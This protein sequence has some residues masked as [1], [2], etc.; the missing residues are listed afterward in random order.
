V[1]GIAAAIDNDFGVVGVAPGARLWAVKVLNKWG[2][3]S[4]SGVIAGIDWVTE[5][6]SEIE[7]ANLSLGTV[8]KS[9]AFRLA[10][11]NSTAAGI[12]Y[13]VAAGNS[14]KDVY[15]DDGTFDTGDDFIPA[16]YPEV[17]AVSAIADS[18]GE[19]GGLGPSTSWGDDDTLALFSN[20]SRDVVVDNPVIA[21]GAAI[22]V[23]APGVDILSTW[24]GNEYNTLSGTSMASPHVAGRAASYI[25]LHGKPLDAEGVATVRQALISGGA[26][27]DGP[28]GFTL[29]FDENPEPLVDAETL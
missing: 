6:A 12:F 21:Y 1:A 26:L 16:A 9:D 20:F 29:D 27:Q 17:A 14:R 8:G 10:L 24:K 3:G 22:D 7:V 23:A 13:A 11:Q 4:L 28:K 18:D 25:A 5:H 19:P 15:G 2:S